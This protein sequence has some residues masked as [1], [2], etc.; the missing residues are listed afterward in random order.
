MTIRAFTLSDMIVRN[1]RLHPDATAFIADG[2]R[3]THAEYLRRVVNLAGSLAALGIGQGDRIAVLAHNCLEYVELY[4]AAARLG[5]IVLAV[6]WRLSTDEIGYILADGAPKVVVADAANQ[7][8]IRAA[9][10]PAS[11]ARYFCIGGAAEPFSPFGE[12]LEPAAAAA[13]PAT[14][15][16]ADGGFVIIP[17]AAVSGRPRGALLSQRGLVA[18]SMQLIHH[19]GLSQHDVNLGA[20]PLFHT[21]GLGLLLAVQMAGGATVLMPRFD[22]E[23]AVRHIHRDRVTVFAEFP[24]MLGAVLDKATGTDELAS[25]RIVTGLESPQTIARLETA[26]ER[27]EFWT[28]YGQSEVSGLVSTARFRECGGSVGQPTLLSTVAIVDDSDDFLPAGQA[29]EIVVRSP[30]VFEGYWNLEAENAITFRNGWHHTGDLGRIDDEGRLWYV[31]RAP[32]KDLIKPGGENVYP[33]EVETVIRAHPAISDVVVLG[34]PDAQW[35]EAIKAVCVARAG[36]SVTADDV[37]AFVADRVARYKKPKHVVFVKSLPRTAAGVIDRLKVKD[38][39]G[40]A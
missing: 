28:G 18:A 5:A 12:L 35:G 7:A 25:L 15:A 14:D 19:W 40:H 38:E 29:G 11:V 39:H 3:I 36:G 2:Q 17:T 34:V 16:G 8:A 31:G 30:A 27:A 9:A 33:A 24:P 13:T 37:I 22:A 23:L 4:G 1:A 26:C 20:L 10:S 21:S 32:S 6:N